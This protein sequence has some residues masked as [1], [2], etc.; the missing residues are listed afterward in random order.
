MRPLLQS[1]LSMLQ[2]PTR[3]KFRETG[4]NFVD[5]VHT[6][7]KPKKVPHREGLHICRSCWFPSCQSASGL[8][9]CK[10]SKPSSSPLTISVILG[11]GWGRRLSSSYYL[12]R[13]TL[14][15]HPAQFPQ[16]LIKLQPPPGSRLTPGMVW[17]FYYPKC[18]FVSA[19]L[20]LNTW[21]LLW[22][23]TRAFTVLQLIREI[24][25]CLGWLSRKNSP[26]CT[27][28]PKSK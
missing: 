7:Q 16:G 25:E 11:A 22:G 19:C 15:T 27:I 9:Q 13:S 17:P 2:L 26:L 23:W 1:L 5:P 8:F 3:R 12:P 6:S 20:Y 28:F 24:K 18:L 14:K 21:N 10:S 4:W